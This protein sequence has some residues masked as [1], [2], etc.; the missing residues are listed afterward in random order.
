MNGSDTPV[1]SD[2]NGERTLLIAVLCVFVVLLLPRLIAADMFLDGLTYA[3]LAR[4]MAEGRGTFWKPFYTATAHPE[5]YDSPPLGIW[6]QSLAFRVF[7]DSTLVEYFWGVGCGSLLMGLIFLAWRTL[8]AGPAGGWW[9]MIMFALFPGV[10]WILTNNLLENTMACFTLLGFWLILLAIRTSSPGAE[11]AFASGAG[12]AMALGLLTKGPP[13]AFLLAVPAA[14]AAFLRS[15]KVRALRITL[16]LLFVAA[17][18]LAAFLASGGKDAAQWARNY[19]T[20]Q[21]FP[22]LLGHRELATSRLSLVSKL[23]AEVAVPLGL[24]LLLH[25]VLRYR[26]RKDEVSPSDVGSPSP[27]RSP[28]AFLFASALLATLPLML[29]P[30]QF[31]WYLFPGLPLWGMALAAAFPAVALHLE[32]YLRGDPRRSGRTRAAVVLAAAVVVIASIS[33]RGAATVRRADLYHDL[34]VRAGALPPGLVVSVRPAGLA[35][36]WYAVAYMQRFFRVSLTAAPEPT[37]RLLDLAAGERASPACRMF[38][39][40][41][42]LRY[43]IGECGGQ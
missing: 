36:D 6:L 34:G 35:T 16:V 33:L 21:L 7:G 19:L 8:R 24:L 3:S 1:R 32:A 18:V 26:R 14:A 39:Q 27:A 43:W 11:V 29:S 15:G 9:P 41:P 30:K 5:F 25:V 38:N 42:P 10:S 37:V 12:A 17:G 4:N 31:G 23:A 28:V 20:G 13:A 40:R 22:S 2:G